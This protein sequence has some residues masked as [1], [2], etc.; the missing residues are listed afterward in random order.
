LLPPTADRRTLL[1]QLSISNTSLAYLPGDHLA[2]SPRNDP[3]FVS[4]LAKRL[5]VKLK[6]R[7]NAT[8]EGGPPFPFPKDC[9]VELA[10]SSYLDFTLANFSRKQL[11]GLFGY[12]AQ[13]TAR[14]SA[15][16]VI[17]FFYFFGFRGFFFLPSLSPRT[18]AC[19]IWI[20]LWQIFRG[21]SWGRVVWIFGARNRPEIRK[22]GKFH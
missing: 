11:G 18:G 22:T 16:Q 12:L 4:A 7:F 10:L 2:V 5:G 9:S 1:V 14:K 13:G 8:T 20:L 6:Q 17:F 21:S 19:L 3:K 15:K